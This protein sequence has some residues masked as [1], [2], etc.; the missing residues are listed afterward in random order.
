MH[1]L[2]MLDNQNSKQNTNLEKSD[3]YNESVE[4]KLS[5]QPLSI[6]KEKKVYKENKLFTEKTVLDH[7]FRSSKY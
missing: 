3:V 4:N 2:S 7:R 5:V 1:R 6:Y